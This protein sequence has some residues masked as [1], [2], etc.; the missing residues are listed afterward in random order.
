LKRVSV[1]LVGHDPLVREGIRRILGGSR[2][3][4]SAACNFLEQVNAEDAASHG[5]VLIVLINGGSV[6]IE[7][8]TLADL[9]ERVPAARVL[10]LAETFQLTP[11]MQAL[12]AGVSG[13]LVSDLSAARL[14]ESLEMVAAGEKVLP[15]QLLDVLSEDNGRHDADSAAMSVKSA[16]LSDREMQLLRCLVAGMPNKLIA[17]RLDISEATVKVHVKA[18]LRKLD[19]RNRTQAAM[20]GASNGVGNML[21]PVE[22]SSPP[23]AQATEVRRLPERHHQFSP[24]HSQRETD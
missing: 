13:Y 3:D 12:R 24:A 20:W 15:P 16:K 1:V 10:V 19:V 18:V 5:E 22:V 23:L 14:V 11:M 8:A 7:E 21:D 6:D 17:R 4:V 9:K 2:F